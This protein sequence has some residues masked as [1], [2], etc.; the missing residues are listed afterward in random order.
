VAR[1]STG[2]NL[3]FLSGGGEMGER[4]RGFDWKKSPLGAPEEWPA[5]LKALVAL[6]L[7]S[8]QPMFMAW[9]SA[10]TWLYNDAF[11]PI[12]GLKHPNALGQPALDVVWSEASEVLTP[13]F[14]SVFSGDAVHVDDFALELDRR[15]QLEEAHFAFSYNPVADDNGNISGLFGVCTETTDQVMAHRRLREAQTRQRRLFEQAPGFIIIMRG[16]EHVVDFINDKHRTLFNSDDWLGKSI[17]DAF[18]SIAGQGFYELLDSVYASGETVEADNAEV[19]YRRTPDG[20]EETRYLSFIYAPSYGEDGAIIGV[21]CEGFDVTERQRSELR[22][23]GLAAFTDRIRDLEDADEIAYVAAETLGTLLS[24]SRAGYGTIDTAAETIT[25]E[26]DWNAEGI[27]SIAG[28]LH[29]RDYGSYIEDLKRGET[30]IVSDAYRDPRTAANADA[31]KAISAQAFVNMPVTEQG[32]FVALLYLNHSEARAW[33]ADEIALMRDVAERTRTAVERRRAEAELRDGE[34]RL[35]FLDELGRATTEATDADGILTITT[36]LL[37]EHLNVSICAYADMEDDQDGFTIRGDWTAAGSRSIVGHYHLVDFGQLAVHNLR[38]G[39][40]LVLN[41][42]RAE[43]PPDEADTFQ[44]IGISATICMPLVKAGKLA[45]LMAVHDRAPRTWTSGEL[46]LVREV[47]VRSWAHVE[48][49]GAEAELKTSEENFR[50]LTRAMPNQAWTAQPDGMLDWF[51]E[52]VYAFSGARVGSLDGEGWAT[53]VHPDDVPA[54]AARWATA[55]KTGEPYETEFRLRRADGVYR[56]HIARAVAIGGAGH[57]ARWIGTNTDIHDQKEAAKTLTDI[58]ATLEQRVAE[59]MAERGRAEEQLRQSQKMEAI[60]QLTG[61]I[62]HDFN[63][64]LAVVIGGL[65]MMQRRLAKGD[66]DVGRFVEAATDG[67]KRAASLTQRLLA[68]SRQQPLEPSVIDPNKLVASMTDLLTRTLGEQIEVETVLLARLWRTFADPLQLESAILNLAVNARDA[69]PEGGKLTIETANVAID[70]AGAKEFAVP[71][72]QYVM[73]A[74]TDT[75]AGM[76]AEVIE[77]AFDPFF[78]TKSVGKGTGLGLSQ[79]FGFVRQSGGHVKLYS[80]EGVG[81]TVKIY[82]ARHYGADAPREITKVTASTEGGK[83]EIILVVED[84]ERVRNYSTEALRELGYTVVSAAGGAEALGLIDAGQYVDLL[85]TD[86]VMPGMN[87]RQLAEKASAKLPKL[88]VLFTT[89]YTRN[90][91]VH[92]GVLDPGTSFVQKPFSVDQLAAKVRTVLD[93]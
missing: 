73:L 12:L 71:A 48:R 49:V 6:M 50:T 37:G 24:V 16:P 65:N 61:G 34:A 85:F 80:E 75:G 2:T 7:Q 46:A 20:P 23:I 4:I 9:G 54:A 81:T 91:V 17:R 31:L 79:V 70:D 15:G 74:V 69:M 33:R 11:T 22:N 93:A 28:T 87:G 58:N 18:P 41:D 35:R 56:W 64:M 44:S 10:R 72:G 36:R 27:K 57:I 52:Q 83:G 30:A 40:P 53:L 76:S 63:N 47:T 1:R 68:F 29:F 60:G 5:P 59:E 82:L 77:K 67:A 39:L 13:L 38:A 89:G 84:E 66:T 3:A 42:N 45:A 8:R 19:R 26:R 78:T 43:L 55:L 32:G 62:A 51:N 88:K 14:D 92:N 25:I 86:V 90:A 21:F